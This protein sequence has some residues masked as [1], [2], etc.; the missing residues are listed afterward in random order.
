[1]KLDW[2]VNGMTGTAEW[3]GVVHIHG[4][5]SGTVKEAK[6]VVKI[7]PPEGM[8]FNG[9]QSWTYTPEWLPA[10]RMYGTGH[11]PQ[12]LLNTFSLDRYGDAFFAKY[13]FLRGR[14]HGY[15]WCWFRKGETYR[16]FASLDESFGYTVFSYDVLRRELVIT[17]DAEGLKVEGDFRAFDLFTAEGGLEEVFAAWFKAMGMEKR[18]IPKLYGYSSWYDRYQDIN[19]EGILKTLEGCKSIFEPGDLFQIDDGWEPYIGDWLE[20]SAEKFPGGMKR[21]AGIIHADGFRAGL[22]MAP[23]V[24]EEKSS[25]FQNHPDW[26]YQKDGKP[27]KCGSNWSGFYALDIDNEDA[28]TYVEKC[29]RQAVEDW[30]FDLLKLD[31]LYGAACFGNEKETRAARMRRALEMLRKWCGN[32]LI[33]GCGV[34]LMPAF[35]LVD[36][37]RIGC[38]VSLD[39]DDKLYMHIAHPERVSTKRS[40][41]DTINRQP[42]DGYAFGC[43]PDVL[44]LRTENLKLSEKQKALLAKVDALCGSVFLTSDDPGSYTEEQKQRYREYRAMTKLEPGKVIHKGLRT[45]LSYKENDA[46]KQ[47]ILPFDVRV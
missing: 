26:F 27:W 18:E 20:A 1:M 11:L 44:F 23:F 10:Q 15:S 9:Y 38:D 39:W 2:T 31:F 14:F 3:N 47:I 22:W 34:P 43:D 32:A 19:E 7:A 17:K 35:G 25:V 28:M 45:L 30:G 29:V 5:F 40:M 8:V 16:L 33:L 46:E 41:T 36:Y 42:L 13:S 24:A 12:N 21:M 6:A 4:P 37:C